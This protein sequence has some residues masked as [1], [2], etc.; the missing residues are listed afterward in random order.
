MLQQPDILID[1]SV[2]DKQFG[3]GQYL[4]VVATTLVLSVNCSGPQALFL[5]QT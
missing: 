3:C 5:Q 2:R 4:A 1:S